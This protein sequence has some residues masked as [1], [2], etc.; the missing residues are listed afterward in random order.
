MIHFDSPKALKQLM[1]HGIA[2]TLRAKPRRQ[3]V[4]SIITNG[5]KI[6]MANV[7]LVGT[8]DLTNPES[9]KPYLPYSGFESI[10]EWIREYRR[11]NG[12]VARA[13]LYEVRLI[14]H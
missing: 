7:R 5:V 14:N 10:G 8:I 1:E 12:N 3:G 9:L 4:T 6:G 13:F 11:L 2:Y